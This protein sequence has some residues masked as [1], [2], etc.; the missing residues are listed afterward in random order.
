MLVAPDG[1]VDKCTVI[2]SS[3]HADLDAATCRIVQR[4]A[5][6]S[7]SKDASGKPAY[8]I[9]DNAI[10]WSLGNVADGA[11]GPQLELKI[12]QAPPGVKL[13]LVIKLSYRTKIDGTAADCKL[14]DASAG[15]PQVLADLG[16]QSILAQPPEIIRNSKG[17]PVEVSNG[18]TVGFSRDR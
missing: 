3:R 7:P 12:N 9:Y 4:R 13:P 5:R 10:T 16:C 11:L 18:M 1:T 6:F 14:D 2:L 15:A 8:G 17:Q